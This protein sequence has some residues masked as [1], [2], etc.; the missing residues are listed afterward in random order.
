MDAESGHLIAITGVPSA[1]KST[2]SRAVEDQSSTL[3]YFDGDQ[4]IRDHPPPVPLTAA[5]AAQTFA[6]MLERLAERM[7]SPKRHS[8]CKPAGLVRRAR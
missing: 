4:F 1:G 2:V 6:L 8:G 5:G 3:T 7:I